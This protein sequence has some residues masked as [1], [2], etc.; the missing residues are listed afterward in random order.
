[1][2]LT[3]TLAVNT[4]VQLVGKVATTIMSIILV[5]ALTRYLGVSGYGTYATVLAYTQFFA[6]F[7]DL[8]VNIYLV[9]Q[10][11]SS[12][13]DPEKELQTA[14]AIRVITNVIVVIVALGL[15]FFLPYSPLIRMGIVIAV[16]AIVAQSFNALFVSVLQA[17]LQMKFAAISDVIGRL[18]L[19]GGALY[20]V[21]S[22]HGIYG[23]LIATTAGAL[24]NLALTF[25]WSQRQVRLHLRWD[26]AAWRL[27]LQDALPISII[28]LLT[29]IYFKVD[30][31]LL[32]VLPLHGGR[33]NTVEVGIYGTAYK[34]LEILLLVPTILIGNLFPIINRLSEEKD[35]R[36]AAILQQI[37]EVLV[38][39]SVA[40]SGM[41]FILAPQIIRLVAGPAFADAALPL[42]ILSLAVL[43]T[44]FSGLFTSTCLV[45]RL[46]RQLM[47]IYLVATVFNIVANSVFI[48]YFSYRAAAV[49]TFFTELVVLIPSFLLIQHRTQLRLR[50]G[51]IGAI[52]LVALPLLGLLYWARDIT[53][54][55]TVPA[56]I[57]AYLGLLF[58]LRIVKRE[59]LQ[60]MFVQ[61]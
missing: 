28:S 30:S 51:R 34:V 50:L 38:M 27:M 43:I 42:Q 8:G 17:R 11:S 15:M 21:A 45:L 9:R 55:I 12:T 2:G 44:Y 22:H 58:S 26:P 14:F 19:L 13:T 3:R 18:V 37:T 56:G 33:V 4:A 6:I 20:V 31:V 53:L 32:S 29:Y 7:A 46:Q 35:S 5:A 36:L 1:M 61:S 16:W 47:V 10:L 39:L 54:F 49:T 59:E 24:L 60:N 40:V 25:F 48:P 52:L 57:V 23:I 41:V